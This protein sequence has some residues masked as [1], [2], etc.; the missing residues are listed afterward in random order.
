MPDSRFD[1]LGRFVL[2]GDDMGVIVGQEGMP[3]VPEEHYAVWYGQ[4][5]SDDSTPLARTVPVE[6]CILIDKHQFYH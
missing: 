6:Y 2:V 3:D 4:K 1:L 5:T